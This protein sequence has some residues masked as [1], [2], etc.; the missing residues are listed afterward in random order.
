M[1][2]LVKLK[3]DVFVS[4][5]RLNETDYSICEQDSSDSQLILDKHSNISLN[6]KRIVYSTLGINSLF[7][8]KSFSM[9]YDEQTINVLMTTRQRVQQ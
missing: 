4:T 2:F 9:W 7:F 1:F 8:N 5:Y 3:T 6:M